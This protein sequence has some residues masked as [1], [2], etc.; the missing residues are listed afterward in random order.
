VIVIKLK[1]AY[2]DNGRQI[3]ER[4]FV[5]PDEEHL[6]LAGTVTLNPDEW[7]EFGTAL[8]IG[9]AQLGGRVIVGFDDIRV[10][11]HKRAVPL[12]PPP[13]WQV[14]DGG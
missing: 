7:Q 4:I 3:D 2:A 9:A 8:A 10:T 11:R 5:G 13:V 14:P 1:S 12:T 6:Q